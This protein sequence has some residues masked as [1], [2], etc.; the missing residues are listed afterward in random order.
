MKK[1]KSSNNK[2]KNNR[3][4]NNGRNNGK[5]HNDTPYYLEEEFMVQDSTDESEN[6]DIAEDIEFINQIEQFEKKYNKAKL[7]KVFD[8]TGKPKIKKPDKLT[9][10]ELKEELLRLFGIFESKKIFVHFK[11]EYPL[12]IKYDFIVNEILNQAVEDVSDSHIHINFIYEDFHPDVDLD[13]EEE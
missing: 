13:D 8:L 3:E 7:I 10:E 12:K 9:D 1:N 2:N 5:D 4:K 6:Q 11:N